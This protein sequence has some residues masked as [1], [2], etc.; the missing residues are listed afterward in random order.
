MTTA[1]KPPIAED[2]LAMV[3]HC[4]GARFPILE[5]LE[6][7]IDFTPSSAARADMEKLKEAAAPPAS[8]DTKPA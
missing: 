5:T 3:G 4:C 8:A 7:G 1:N 2:S 6:E